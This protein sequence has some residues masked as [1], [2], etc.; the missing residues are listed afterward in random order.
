LT[1]KHNGTSVSLLAGNTEGGPSIIRGLVNFF[2]GKIVSSTLNEGLDALSKI[3]E[4]ETADSNLLHGT[5]VDISMD[6]IEN[7]LSESLSQV[8]SPAS[9]A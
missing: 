8:E 7:A 2:G 5:V 1:E 9:A 6:Q 3:I 4:T